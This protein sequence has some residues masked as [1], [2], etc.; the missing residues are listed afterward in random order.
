MKVSSSL[1]NGKDNVRKYVS[2]SISGNAKH[3]PGISTERHLRWDGSAWGEKAVGTAIA[4]CTADPERSKQRGKA[5]GCCPSPQRRLCSSA[6]VCARTCLAN[7]FG[8]RLCQN[9]RPVDNSCV[10]T[11]LWSG[12]NLCIRRLLLCLLGLNLEGSWWQLKSWGYKEKFKE[13]L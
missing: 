12:I 8:Q 9:E 7:R 1:G 6:G 4:V 5:A 13:A 3:A 2:E 10:C 11:P